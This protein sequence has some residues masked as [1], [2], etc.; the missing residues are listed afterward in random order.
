MEFMASFRAM[1]YPLLRA[2]DYPRVD[3]FLEAMASLR[4]A[5]LLDPLRIEIAVEQA[6]RF[7]AAAEALKLYLGD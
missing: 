6:Q 5:D 1:G 2:P 3:T 7:R 4:D